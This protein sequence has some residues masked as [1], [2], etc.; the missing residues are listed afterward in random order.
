M[1][2]MVAPVRGDHECI[3][4]ARGFTGRI[5]SSSLRDAITAMR[6]HCW[7]S[8]LRY[9]NFGI[10][11]V[12]VFP[13]RG[14]LTITLPSMIRKRS[15]Q[16]WMP[17]GRDC[18]HYFR[19]GCG[20]HGVVPP[21]EGFL[22]HAPGYKPPYG[23]LSSLMRYHGLQAYLCGIPEYIGNIT[24]SDMPGKDYRGRSCRRVR[25]RKVLWRCWPRGTGLSGRNALGQPS[26]HVCGY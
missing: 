16:P 1:V 5:R 15:R 12:P 19:T 26:R 24:G 14:E 9:C 10:P 17:A 3:R 7:Q 20:Q 21:K 13:G 22:N 23:I 6:I 25:G 2:R 18:V 8:R 4:L 11:E